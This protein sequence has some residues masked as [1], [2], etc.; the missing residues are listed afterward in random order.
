MR[1]DKTF[2]E[3]WNLYLRENLNTELMNVEEYEEY[4]KEVKDT[5]LMAINTIKKL[6][7]KIRELELEN[8]QLKGLNRFS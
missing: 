7:Q 4:E 2:S 3:L 1:V 8:N 6:Q 5:S